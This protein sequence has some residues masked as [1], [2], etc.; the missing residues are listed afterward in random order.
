M[1][2]QLREAFRE[3]CPYRYA[4]LDRDAKF[5]KDVTDLLIS[6]GIKPKRIG[7]HCPWQKDYVSYCTSLA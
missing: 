6:S 7:Y 3:A 4:L 5:G 1:Q 2:Q